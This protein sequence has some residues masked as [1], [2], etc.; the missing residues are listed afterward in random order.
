MKYVHIAY[1]VNARYL[2]HALLRELLQP[3]QILKDNLFI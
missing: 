1:N 2:A 3:Q